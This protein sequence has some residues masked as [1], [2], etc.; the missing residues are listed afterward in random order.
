MHLEHRLR[1]PRGAIVRLEHLVHHHNLLAHLWGR[2]GGRRGERM[3]AGPEQRRGGGRTEAL[4]WAH[5][6]EERLA[7]GCA[8]EAAE[9]GRVE[10]CDRSIHIGIVHLWGEGAVMSTCMRRIGPH[11]YCPHA[12]SGMQSALIS[13]NQA[14]N[15]R[16]SGTQSGTQSAHLR[17]QALVGMQSAV[18][19]HA[20][21]HAISPPSAAG[22]QSGMQSAVIRHAIRHA[23]SPPSAAGTGRHPW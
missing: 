4:C 19:R 14:C 5:R 8:S 18:I 17:Q 3:H 1:R 11:W 22:T 23:I 10:G 9:D 12:T 2:G 6:I 15:Q 7:G 20:I 16:S 21:R 13:H